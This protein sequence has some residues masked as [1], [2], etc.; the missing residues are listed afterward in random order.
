MGVVYHYSTQAFGK[1]DTIGCYLDMDSGVV[2]YSKN[3]V[4]LKNNTQP[5]PNLY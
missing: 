5:I 2:G 1:G 4:C 3:G